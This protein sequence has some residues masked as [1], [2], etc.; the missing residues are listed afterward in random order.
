M[1]HR[2]KIFDFRKVFAAFFVLLTVFICYMTFFYEFGEENLEN[3]S[4]ITK[5]KPVQRWK[6][7]YPYPPEWLYNI[8][9]EL[10]FRFKFFPTT[11]QNS[12]EEMNSEQKELK[13]IDG[14]KY[15]KYGKLKNFKS[16]CF[17]FSY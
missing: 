16:F 9:G 14:K 7:D 6:E 4:I 8:S 2:K 15:T 10:F 12:S 3:A 13:I 11:E 5:E 1:M 17:L